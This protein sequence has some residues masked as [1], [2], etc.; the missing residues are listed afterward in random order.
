MILDAEN[1][2][3]LGDNSY[4]VQQVTQI[5]LKMTQNIKSRTLKII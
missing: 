5:I 4:L 2:S 3:N 1:C